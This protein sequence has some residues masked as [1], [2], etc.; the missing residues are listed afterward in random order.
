MMH[1]DFNPLD[2]KLLPV[3]QAQEVAL[4]RRMYVLVGIT[5][6]L[7]VTLVMLM[8][9]RPYPVAMVVIFVAIIGCKYT[10]IITAVKLS[11][12][13]YNARMSLRKKGYKVC[14]GCM[15]DL[16]SLEDQGVC[17]ECGL[18]YTPEGL[19]SM[20][21]GLYTKLLQKAGR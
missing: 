2:V 12:L 1:G 7:A 16:E 20:W 9:L 5:F 21:E 11:G 19:K 8:T 14:P 18:A 6:L 3:S 15:Y 13:H 17:P 4:R 10:L